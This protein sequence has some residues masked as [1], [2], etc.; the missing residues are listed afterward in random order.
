MAA[1]TIVLLQGAFQLP[2]VYHSFAKLIKA[3][4]F[5][6]VQP[7]FPSLNQEDPDFVTKDLSDDA[8]AVE[9]IL[10]KLIKEE[11]KTVVVVM[12]SYGGLVG[13]EAVPEELTL[14]HRKKG[15]LAGGVIHLFY[16]AAFVM[17]P[18][19]SV[20]KTV[21]PSPDHDLYDGKFKMRNPLATMYSDLPKDDAEYW[22]A[23]VIPQS[24]AV[25]DTT[26]KKCA[27]SYVPSTYVVCTADK[28][29]PPPVQE[30]FAGMAGSTRKELDS[31]HSA[32]LSKPEEVLALIEEIAHEQA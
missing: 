22:A 17:P 25:M 16:L 31:G 8:A 6:V 28:A 9:S 30:M 4:G 21:G 29:V 13:G 12:H 14:K 23:K 32:F 18:G 24:A 19:Q 2:E 26:M 7:P 11:S 27:W 3:R 5:P 15:G 1:P 10:C 20:M